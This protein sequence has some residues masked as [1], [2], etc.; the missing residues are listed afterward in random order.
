MRTGTSSVTVEGPV[1]FHNIY[2]TEGRVTLILE[3]AKHGIQKLLTK[4]LGF[5]RGPVGVLED[6]ASAAGPQR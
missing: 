5:P 3:A 1:G 2:F 6:K 4:E